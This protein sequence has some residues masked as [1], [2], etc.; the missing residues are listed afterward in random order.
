MPDVCG[1][2]GLVSISIVGERCSMRGDSLFHRVTRQSNV[3][4]RLVDR[5]C[6]GDIR[7]VDNGAGKALVFQRTIVLV[8]AVT[9]RS[10]WEL[11][12]VVFAKDL[13]V[14]SRQDG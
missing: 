7:A 10:R 2:T 3:E 5:T 12:A 11:S 8:P 9:E 4:F 1:E 13:L 6:S 14:M